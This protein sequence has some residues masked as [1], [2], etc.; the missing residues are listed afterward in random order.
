MT[1]PRDRGFPRLEISI[2]QG[3]FI[4]RTLLIRGN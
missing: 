3:T 4:E 1:N 2:E